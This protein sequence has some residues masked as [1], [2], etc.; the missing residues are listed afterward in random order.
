MPSAM[1]PCAERLIHQKR[2]QAF[3]ATYLQQRARPPNKLTAVPNDQNCAHISMRD[4]A[5]HLVDHGLLVKAGSIADQLRWDPLPALSVRRS[6]PRHGANSSPYAGPAQ[7]CGRPPAR[8]GRRYPRKNELIHAFSSAVELFFLADHAAA[9]PQGTINSRRSP[10]NDLHQ[11]S[12]PQ[13]NPAFLCR[14]SQDLRPDRYPCGRFCAVD[15][16]AGDLDCRRDRRTDEMS[17]TARSGLSAMGTAG[18]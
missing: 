16:A 6:L 15:A 18:R 9:V 2:S 1:S 12:S 11:L 7:Y 8:W 14:R 5:Q 10:Q 17:V 13:G 3:A 4:Q